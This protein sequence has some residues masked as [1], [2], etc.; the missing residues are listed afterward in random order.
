M[1]GFI[2]LLI[3]VLAMA[4]LLMVSYRKPGP[5]QKH[6]HHRPGEAW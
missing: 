4:I 5:D 6:P 3:A 1:V 2:L